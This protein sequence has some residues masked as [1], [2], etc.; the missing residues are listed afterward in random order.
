MQRQVSGLGGTTFEVTLTASDI[1]SVECEPGRERRAGSGHRNRSGRLLWT[2]GN[3][4]EWQLHV[5]RYRDCGSV[6]PNT[7]TCPNA[8]WTATVVDVDF[9]SDA[10]LTLTEDGVVSDTLVV[11]ID[12]EA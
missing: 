12:P 9:T 5:R 6:V 4:A 1:G 7:P 3:A 10:T 2:P 11:P 8:G